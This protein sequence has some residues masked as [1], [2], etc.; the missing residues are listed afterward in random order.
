MKRTI[1]RVTGSRAEW[2]LFYP[3]A[4]EI[5]KN[6]RH[7]IL[8][9][10]AT[11]AHLSPRFGLTYREIEKDG[12]S[13]D[14][15]VKMLVK[16]GGLSESVSR[17]I[18]GLTGALKRLKPD[19]VLLLG[20][21]FETFSAAAAC[22][23]LK[24][25]VAHIH[26]GEI[27]E[28]S[29]D[30]IMRHAITKM[31]HLHF[32]STDAYR[33]RVI[34]MGE[35]PSRVFNVGALGLD[36]IKDTKL[37]DRREFEER[38]KFRLGKKNVMVTFH[39]STA[40][41]KETTETQL[42][43]LLGAAGDLKDAKIILTYPNPDIY[44]DTII[45]IIDRFAAKNKEK[46]VSFASMGRVLYL[47]ALKHVDVVA[48]NSSSGIIEAPS[49]GIPTINIGNRERG[50]IKGETVI[51]AQ[52]DRCSID[53]AFWKALSGDFRK[54]CR[55]AVS[56]YGSGTASKKIV[57]ILKKTEVTSTQKRFYDP[58]ARPYCRAGNKEVS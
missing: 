31:S 45:R 6:K 42:K 52:G 49:F 30:D 16:N 29:Q 51:D 14:N 20:D 22:L 34:R 36:N 55:S 57:Y 37:L 18:K 35:D 11:G 2:G 53:N 7:F 5:R 21:R 4:R 43:N 3:L 40:E 8:R 10:I 23:F 56:L 27:T 24:I 41:E 1:A 38:I 32:V 13:I 15:K 19:I 50:R 12:F 33:N 28:G 26:G 46:A 47:S 44:S 9:I 25:P 54:R 17:G 39:P 48:G 58:P